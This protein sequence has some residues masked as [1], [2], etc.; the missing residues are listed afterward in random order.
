MKVTCAQESL[1]KTLSIVGRAVATKSTLPVLANVLVATEDSKL[2]LAATNLEIAMTCWIAANVEEEG[3]ITIPARLLSE[4]V[5]SMPNEKVSINLNTKT[6]SINIKCNRYQANIKGIDPDEFPPIPKVGEET[7]LTI[8]PKVLHQAISQVVF[9]AATDDTRPVLG[10]VLA[11]FRG[12]E[13]TLA[14]ADG[15]R[16][17]VRQLKLSNAVPSDLDI[18]IP[19]KSLTELGRIIGDEAEPI[20]IAVTPNKTQALFHVTK[21]DGELLSVDLVSRLIE[22]SFPPYQQ[23]IPSKF[24]TKAEITTADFSKATRVASFFARD[25]SNVVK[26]QLNKGEDMSP[27]EL[28]VA[29]T[30]AEVG[31]TTTPIEAVV[32]GEGTQIAFNA[33]YLT[34]VL[35]VIDQP[36]VAL[37]LTSPSAPGVFR[38]VGDDSYT[39]V[40]MPMHTA[41]R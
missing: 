18:I 39:H 28:T 38:P 40:I 15:F 24:T 26:L 37:E 23:I 2:K 3:S 34:D 36:K 5:A 7:R 16:L 31:D 29:A 30:A 4:L 27:G 32:E 17:S 25:A 21:S 19:A 14:A 12:D 9:A 10:G 8:D 1:A 35:A 22:G 13:L 41:S 33:K 11:R 20:V 6:N